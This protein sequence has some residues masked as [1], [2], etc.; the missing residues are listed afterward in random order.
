MGAELFEI[1]AV[2]P[3]FLLSLLADVMS[4]CDEPGHADM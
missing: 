2:S 3:F 4:V 1:G